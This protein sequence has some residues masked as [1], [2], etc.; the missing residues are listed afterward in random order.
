PEVRRILPRVRRRRRDLDFLRGRSVEFQLEIG[1]GEDV[2]VHVALEARLLPG[3]AEKYRRELRIIRSLGLGPGRSLLRERGGREKNPSEQHWRLPVDWTRAAHILRP[4]SGR[5]GI[6]MH[7]GR[8]AARGG[9]RRAER[10]L[11]R[12]VAASGDWLQR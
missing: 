12:L 1:I 6:D 5:R 8:G 3:L 10:Q 4:S 7:K 11:H 2:G 9:G